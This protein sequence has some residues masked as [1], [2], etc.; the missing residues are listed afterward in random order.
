M[1]AVVYDNIEDVEKH[2]QKRCSKRIKMQAG[3][4]ALLWCL[5][6]DSPVCQLPAWSCTLAGPAPSRARAPPAAHAEPADSTW[7]TDYV[8]LHTLQEQI[9]GPE[10]HVHVV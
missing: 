5:E 1:I 4:T 3:R 7:C 9:I 2:L 6:H 10:A 8:Y